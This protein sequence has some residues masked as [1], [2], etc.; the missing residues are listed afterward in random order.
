M[1]CHHNSK[2]KL[3][4]VLNLQRKINFKVY[5]SRKKISFRIGCSDHHHVPF[6]NLTNL[7]L[8]CKRE[9]LREDSSY[10]QPH[11]LFE[12]NVVNITLW[13]LMITRY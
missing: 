12:Q 9:R 4:L 13:V 1:T 7:P 10:S 8:Q 5:F 6:Q 3:L 2:L 11:Y